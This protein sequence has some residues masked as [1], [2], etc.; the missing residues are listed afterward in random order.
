MQFLQSG[1]LDYFMF[2]GGGRKVDFADKSPGS[3]A[4][5]QFY[6]R[7]YGFAIYDVNIA[8]RTMSVTY[9]VFGQNGAK[10]DTKWLLLALAAVGGVLYVGSLV[11]LQQSLVEPATSATDHKTTLLLTREA[12]PGDGTAPQQEAAARETVDPPRETPSAAPT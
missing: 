12:A 1:K 8:A 9:H 4:N 10:V 3:K 5:V 7:N 6:A 2:G 11:G